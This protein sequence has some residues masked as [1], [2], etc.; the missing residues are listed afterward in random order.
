MP[1]EDTRRTA[2]RFRTCPW[3]I[4]VAVSAAI[5]GAGATDAAEG[6]TFKPVQKGE[7]VLIFKPRGV[8]PDQIDKAQVR[9]RHRRG[10]TQR[11]V[12]AARVRNALR[13]RSTLRVRRPRGSKGG[14][15][16]VTIKRGGAAP[17]SLDSCSWGSFSASRQP[18]ACWRPYGDASPFNTPVAG[19]PLASNSAA[20]VGRLTWAS[21]HPDKVTTGNSGTAGDWSHPI[22]YSQ[23]SDPLY[24][25]DC[26]EPWGTCEIEGMQVRIPAQAEPAG[27]SDG[28]MAVIDQASG[29]EYDFWQVASKPAGGGTI[30]ISWGGRTAI[31]TADADGR[32]SNATAA[33]FGLAAGVI[34]PSELAAGEIN[35]ALFMVVKC[36]SGTSVYPAGPGAG[37]A[38]ADKTN[39]PAM[40]QHFYLDMTDAEIEALSVPAWQKTI[41]RA[42]ARYGLYVGDTGGGGWG[43]QFESGSSFTSF[44]Q[45]DPWVA[46]GDQLGATK[47][48]DPSSGRSLRI[49][50]LKN[51][52]PW[53]SKLKVAT[54]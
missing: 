36:T 20:I 31:G 9:V 15:L 46:L 19:K 50:D 45:T 22:Y 12:S 23:P 18:G 11:P 51:A 30:S 37:S 8:A 5:I 7:R 34:R 49:W 2:S 32:D 52:A 39:A 48:T 17:V 47:W 28:H 26:T 38:C 24:T 21:P 42:M 33:H 43:I 3:A 1:R 53:A 4:A 41:L 6:A 10:R 40:G 54:S 25:I 14:S 16:K 35:H 29:W 44:G 13:Q 27:G